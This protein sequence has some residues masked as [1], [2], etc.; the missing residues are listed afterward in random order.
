MSTHHVF[1]GGLVVIVVVGWVGFGLVG[2]CHAQRPR[3]SP[4][5]HAVV[6]VPLA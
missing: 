6:P 5:G 1:I 2:L 3:D 4:D